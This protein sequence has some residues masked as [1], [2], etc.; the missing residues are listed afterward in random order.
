MFAKVTSIKH[1]WFIFV[2]ILNLFRYL[3]VT[4]H[5]SLTHGVYLMTSLPGR[6][7]AGRGVCAAGRQTAVECWKWRRDSLCRAPPPSGS[8]TRDIF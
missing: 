8:S 6:E 5:A 7:Q 3:P 2:P 1:T 4:E